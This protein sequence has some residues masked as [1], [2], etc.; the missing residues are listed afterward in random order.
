MKITVVIPVY[1]K[2]RYIGRALNSVLA[3][4]HQD[5]EII[6]VDDGSS[7]DSAAIIESF[8]GPRI[9]CIRQENQGVSV[10]RNF[11]IAEAKTDWIA[12]L[13]ADDEYTPTFLERIA[14]IIESDLDPEVVFIGSNYLIGSVTPAFSVLETEGVRDFFQ[15]FQNGKTPNNSSSTVARK[16]KLLALGGF[17]VGVKQFEDWITW[18]KLA[19]AGR[20]YFIPEVL[21]VYHQ[22]EG[23]AARLS[24]PAS[25]VFRDAI[26]LQQSWRDAF[27]S[28]NLSPVDRKAAGR[29]V[30][31]F[32]IIVACQLAR[33]HGKI[34]AIRLLFKCELKYFEFDR[35][36]DQAFLRNLFYLIKAMIIPQWIR[37][38]RFN[39]KKYKSFW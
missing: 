33:I 26:L 38:L 34:V 20:F 7:D 11:G 27:L 3:Q 18:G 30:N 35:L 8:L 24:R 12:F 39:Y 36:M 5:W 4:N 17:P 32:C 19:I 28:H 6:A 13:D 15:M 2:S 37:K 10:A 29:C 9:R 23:S 1:N 25:E 16:D 31:D 22:V 14:R 21:S